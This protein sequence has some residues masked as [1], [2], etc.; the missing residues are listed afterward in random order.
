MQKAKICELMC[1]PHEFVLNKSSYPSLLFFIL[2]LASTNI[3]IYF[4]ST[5][6]DHKNPLRVRSRLSLSLYTFILTPLLIPMN[7]EYNWQRITSTIWFVQFSLVQ[8]HLVVWKSSYHAT[9]HWAGTRTRFL[10]TDLNV[11]G[12]LR[13]IIP[14]IIVHFSLSLFYSLI[15]VSFF[16]I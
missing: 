10:S 15:S 2:H 11:N 6:S 1:L 9:V 4:T 16:R 3:T 8:F 14:L 13:D 7:T 12:M 5:R